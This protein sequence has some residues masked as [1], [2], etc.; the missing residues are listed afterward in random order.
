MLTYRDV[1]NIDDGDTIPPSDP[2]SEN[3]YNLIKS[4]QFNVKSTSDDL[5]YKSNISPEEKQ[6]ID[7]EPMNIDSQQLV[8]QNK[9]S[10]VD[11]KQQVVSQPQWKLSKV[12]ANAHEGWVRSCTMD[13]VSNRWYVTGGSDATIKVWDL[14]TSQIKATLTGHI[15]GVRSLKVS[16]KFP[17][18]FSGSEDK[19]VR[20]WDLERTNSKAGCQ[21]RD[22][23]GHVGG[24]Y[25]MD[26]HPEL[27]ILCTGGRD[28][29]IRVWDI[30]SRT[31]I[32]LLS[33]HRADITSISCSASDPQIVSSS[34]DSTIR[35]WDIRKATTQ[36][37][38]THHSKSIR[39]M[40]SHPNEMTMCSADSAGQFK[41]WVLPR[42]DLLN[43][44]ATTND[45]SKIVNSLAINPS[46]DTLFAGYDD[47]RMEFYDY[48]SGN[49]VQST[50]SKPV[51]GTPETTIYASTFDKSGSRLITCEGDKSI[52]IWVEEG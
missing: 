32:M 38:I 28:S 6:V 10:T 46:N 15:M 5:S 21:I 7:V 39:S 44:F 31:E 23:H 13:P 16:S 3:F 11:N 47:G 27:D 37:A 26:L 29:V 1:F 52:K 25:A 2:T 36:L 24:I 17:Y 41:Q 30:R 20:C 51:P 40:V 22:Y 34:M 49:L 4:E 43:E 35:L 33:G 19:T 8:V 45:D 50:T 12:I 9:R 18:L 42:G 14:A 48:K